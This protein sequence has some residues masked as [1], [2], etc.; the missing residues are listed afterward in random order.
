MS[1]F[2]GEVFVVRVHNLLQARKINF[3]IL[4]SC[5]Y[6]SS[7]IIVTDFFLLFDIICNVHFISPF[8]THLLCSVCNIITQ[9]I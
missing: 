9:R 3:Y 7:V 1:H 5:F 2:K 6:C 8:E 4:F